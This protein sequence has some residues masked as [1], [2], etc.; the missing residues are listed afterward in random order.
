MKR[1]V[2]WSSGSVRYGLGGARAG[3]AH[4]ET[5]VAILEAK[6]RFVPMFDEIYWQL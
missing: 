6:K 4:G 2:I 1:P 3:G 5:N